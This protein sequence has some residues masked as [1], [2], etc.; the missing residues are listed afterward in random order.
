MIYESMDSVTEV[1]DAVRCS[2]EILHAL[3]TPGVPPGP[4][5]SPTHTPMW[6]IPHEQGLIALAAL[7][8][9]KGCWEFHRRDH[10]RF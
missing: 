5:L 8:L 6:K 4:L 1:K 3:E 2:T 10:H 7:V 9:G